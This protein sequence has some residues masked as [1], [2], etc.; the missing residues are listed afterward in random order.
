MAPYSIGN[1]ATLKIGQKYVNILKNMIFGIVGVL[2][3]CLFCRGPSFSQVVCLESKKGYCGGRKDLVGLGAR[4]TKN[5]IANKIAL[6][7]DS[8]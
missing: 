7:D 6:I 8:S 1:K 4:T 3:L 5:A 2:L